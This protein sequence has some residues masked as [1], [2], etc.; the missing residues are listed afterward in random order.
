MIDRSESRPETHVT[1][2]GGSGFIGRYVC[3]Y[4]LQ[5]GVRLRVAVR[6]PRTAFFLQPLAQVGQ[7]GAV[8]ADL[9]GRESV[10]AAVKGADCVI[11]LCGAFR[12]MEAVHV[13]GARIVAE[14]ARAAG[15]SSLVHVSAIGAD[16]QSNS[17]YGRTKG[18][19][20][21]AVR[22]AFPG[23]TIIRPSLVFG[24]EDALTN[25]FAAMGRMP[26]VP[27]LAAKVRFQPVYV[28]DL[29]QAI[30]AATLDPA[31]HGGKI[32]EIGGPEVLT[33]L[34][35]QRAIFAQTGQSPDLV[36][37]PDIA[38]TLLSKFG[39]LPGAPLTGDQWK[40]LQHDNIVAPGAQGLAAF[41]IAPTPLAAVAGEW[42]DRFRSRKS[43][44]RR[45]TSSTAA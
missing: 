17:T 23:A 14:E 45:L 40:M 21:D 33:M 26:V 35:L 29:A 32:Y 25:R 30:A 9:G 1:I 19:G 10:A 11:N 6:D 8:R 41:G 13:E 20:E 15:A 2:F 38:G 37:L 16:P 39:F 27:V 5:A 18:E 34:D 24:P 42:L 28:R 4:L 12:T 31:R 3:E 43:A 7:F 36:E 22:A 44:G